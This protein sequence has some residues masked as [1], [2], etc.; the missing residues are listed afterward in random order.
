VGRHLGNL[1]SLGPPGSGD[2]DDRIELLI[3]GP[4]WVTEGVL[5]LGSTVPVWWSRASGWP[6]MVELPQSLGATR[7]PEARLH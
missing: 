4:L 2:P 6:D 3:R 1:R 7:S 5:C